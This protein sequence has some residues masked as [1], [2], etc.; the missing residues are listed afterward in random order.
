MRLSQDHG[1]WRRFVA[2]AALYLTGSRRSERRALVSGGAVKE[3][4]LAVGILAISLNA[5]AVPFGAWEWWR[6]RS[7]RWFWWVLRAGQVAVVVQVALGGI[8]VALGHK[9][10]GLHVLYGVLPLLVALIAEQLRAA[11]AQ[12]VLDARGLPSAQA[13]GELP[14]D[15]QRALVTTI[16]QREVGVMTIAALVVVVLLLRAAQTAP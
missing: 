12:M 16:M 4:H 14:E 15:D 11:S 10:P 13:V 8:L 7:D 3:V 5:V 2:A 9:P 1:E 6:R